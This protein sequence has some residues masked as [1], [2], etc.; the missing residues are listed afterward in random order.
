MPHWSDSCTFMSAREILMS[1]LR[2]CVTGISEI[3]KNE[4]MQN[5]NYTGDTV[6]LLK[7]H[8]LGFNHFL[9][10]WQQFG[11]TKRSAGCEGCS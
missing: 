10:F 5:I 7:K 1:P 4:Q 3:T 6:S 9:F 8:V 2:V 11:D